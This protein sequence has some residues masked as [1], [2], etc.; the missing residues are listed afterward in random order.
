MGSRAYHSTVR[1]QAAAA[2]RAAILDAAEELFHSHG[3]APTTIAA[4]ADAA[5]VAQNTVYVTFG[6]KAALVVALVERGVHDSA[7]GHTLADVGASRCGDDV[8][9]ITANGT[10]TTIK[11]HQRTMS[12]LY[13]NVTADPVIADT[14]RDVD[15]AQRDRLRQIAARLVELDALRDGVNRAAA[16][17]ALWFYFGPA[18]WRRLR[19]M[20]WSWQRCEHWLAD[21]AATALLRPTSA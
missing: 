8:I 21:Q 12:V 16:A 2:T 5:G 6:G 15:A 9:R 1:T 20:G 7:V 10:G 3:Y 17:D 11:R 19:Q 4:V 13:D 18:A 14:A